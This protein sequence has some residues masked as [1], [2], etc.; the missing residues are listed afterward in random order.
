M[1]SGHLTVKKSD[2]SLLYD[3]GSIS[4]GLVK[5]GYLA[6]IENWK[7][8][9]LRGI[10]VDPNLASSWQDQSRSGDEQYSFSL[11]N[12]RSPIVFLVGK[13]VATGVKVSETGKTYLFAGAQVSTR[14][15]CFDLMKDDA[16]V[17]ASLKTRSEGGVITFNS[18]QIPL[19]VVSSIVAPGPGALDLHGRPVLAYSGGRNEINQWQ[20]AS[21][22]C[23]AHCV[24]D[25]PLQPGEEYAAF[26]P[27]SRSCGVISD[28]ISGFSGKSIWGVSEG[29]YGRTGGISFLFASPGRVQQ[30][31]WTTTNQANTSYEALPVDRFPSALVIK[32]AGLPF[33]FN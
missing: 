17:G 25:I 22:N 32:T 8:L 14:Y 9:E 1:A 7:R 2:G 20:N 27:W 26:L 30:Q 4:Y 13:G 5:S 15:Y 23:M 33:P 18:G 6:Y 11:D 10:N 19:N 3:T 16:S 12:P 28:Y 21:V 24:V 29:A 31:Q